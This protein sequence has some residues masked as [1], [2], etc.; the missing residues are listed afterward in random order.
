MRFLLSMVLVACTLPVKAADGGEPTA[1][2]WDT[3][4]SILSLRDVVTGIESLHL[5]LADFNF[6]GGSLLFG[7]AM[8]ESSPVEVFVLLPNPKVGGTVNGR[9][10]MVVS[11]HSH[12]S[13]FAIA[14]PSDPLYQKFRSLILNSVVGVPEK[15]TEPKSLEIGK[16][17]IDSV[18]K[19]FKPP[20]TW[21]YAALH[22]ENNGEDKFEGD[23]DGIFE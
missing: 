17:V 14:K 3:Q 5:R 9:Q 12:L 21:G 22:Q 1:K 2:T 13:R 16:Q 18:A 7:F 19:D 20:R 10:T 11:N 8:E 23:L 6:D 15:L 4:R